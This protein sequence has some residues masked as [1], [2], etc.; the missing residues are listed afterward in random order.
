MVAVMLAATVP[1][2][3]LAQPPGPPRVEAGAQG[4]APTPP[5]DNWQRVRPGREVWVTTSTG[6][7]VH[8]EVSAIS[9]RSL[10]IRQRT[11]DVTITLDDIRLVEGRDS[12]KNGIIIGAASGA[13]AA[14]VFFASLLSAAECPSGP[15]TCSDGVEAFALGGAVGAVGGGLLGALVDGLIHGRQTLFDSNTIRFVPVVT[16]SKKAVDLTISWR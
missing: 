14:G 4:Q 15:G 11:G 9:G 2:V 13:L 16:P 7:L 10:D 8:G 6:A 12:L 3:A 5:P 1:S